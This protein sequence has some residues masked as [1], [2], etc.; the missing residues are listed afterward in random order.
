MVVE[1][2]PVKQRIYHIDMSEVEVYQFFGEIW[3]RETIPNG[4]EMRRFCQMDALPF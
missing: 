3:G 2:R 1:S 4:T